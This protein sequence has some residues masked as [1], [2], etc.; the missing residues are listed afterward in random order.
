MM[1]LQIYYTASDEEDANWIVEIT[2]FNLWY[3]NVIRVIRQLEFIHS[4]HFK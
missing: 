2:W 3:L 1:Q 4:F